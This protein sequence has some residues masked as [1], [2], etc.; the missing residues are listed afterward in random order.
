MVKTVAP[1]Q[2]VGVP[3]GQSK[4]RSR[5]GVTVVAIKRPGSD[6]TYAAADT[7]VQPGD[8]LIV[9]GRTHQVEAFAALT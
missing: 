8:L 9:A 2:A 3:L 1:E 4:L 6:F 7:I 5:H